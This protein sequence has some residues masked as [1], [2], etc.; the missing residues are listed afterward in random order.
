VVEHNDLNAVWTELLNSWGN[1]IYMKV[2]VSDMSAFYSVINLFVVKVDERARASS[3]S[4]N[5]R[6]R[7]A[8]TFNII[9]IA[10][11]CAFQYLHNRVYSYTCGMANH[12]LSLSFKSGPH[13][14]LKLL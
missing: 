12:H 5:K 4:S 3:S 11:G 13:R 1:E 10:D 8:C 9:F 7:P 6:T 14:G 2:S